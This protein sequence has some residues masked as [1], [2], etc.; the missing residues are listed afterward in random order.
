MRNPNENNFGEFWKPCV[1]ISGFTMTVFF[2]ML[3]IIISD[4]YY[5][6]SG[7][8]TLMKIFT[9]SAK[10]PKLSTQYVFIIN[11]GF[12]HCLMEFVC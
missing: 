2:V 8:V 1:T 4:A 11:K 3:P 5:Q 10:L 6:Y 7:Y 9:Y 12:S